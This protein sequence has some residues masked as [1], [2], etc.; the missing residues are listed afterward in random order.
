MEYVFASALVGLREGLEATLVVSVL[1]AYLVKSD[2]RGSI[3]WVWLGVGVAV[4]LSV[5]VGALI[6]F[7]SNSLDFE[8]QET[9]GGVMS[10]IAVAFVTAMVFWMR[11]A[12]R[13]ISGELRGK[14]SDAV[15]I[16]PL[17]IVVLAFLSVG[18]E[19]LETAVFFYASAQSAGN[20]S[21][22]L[23]G[24]VIGIALAVAI[25][26]A[27]YRGALRINLSRFF[28]WTGIL[29]IFVAA[30]VLGYGLHDLQEAGVL[31][32]LNTLA[33]DLSG[34]MPEDS[35]YGALLKGIFNYSARTSVVQAAAWV[36]Y[37]AITLTA[38][39]WPARTVADP[40]PSQGAT[41]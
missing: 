15:A 39:L 5:G 10:L 38:F 31:P 37:V 14:L 26:W 28:T 29:L 24:F 27:L 16:G 25:G 40:V 33:F 12:A 2:R 13:K 23:V 4:A 18:R 41:P 34:P 1:L 32:G 17:A 35:W 36:A 9:F 7:T 11:G 6:T 20:N 3:R 8:A 22:P 30:G 19:G 21:G